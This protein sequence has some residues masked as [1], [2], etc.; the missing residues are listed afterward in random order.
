MHDAV[1]DSLDTVARR[2]A[3]ATLR[4]NFRG[5][6]ASEGRFD[7]G[8]GEV[9]DALA[10]VGWLRAEHPGLPLWIAGYSFGASVAWRALGRAGDV[11]GALLV[12]PPIGRMAFGP[13][14]APP[15]LVVVA[16]DRD[17]FVNAADLDRWLQQAAPHAV[18]ETITGADHFFSGAHARLG[19]AIERAL[20]GS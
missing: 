7:G 2:H 19:A 8:D 4:F 1:L 9:D 13:L 14:A 12:A 3:F 5:V 18:R 20:A 10:A 6:G 15:Q 11:E 17:D 16:G